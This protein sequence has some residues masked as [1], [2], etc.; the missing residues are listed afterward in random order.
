MT[1]ISG[2]GQFKRHEPGMLSV[3]PTWV[4]EPQVCGPIFAVS[5]SALEVPASVVV[6][7]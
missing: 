5:V 2:A 1:V 3:S 4:A 6:M 7:A